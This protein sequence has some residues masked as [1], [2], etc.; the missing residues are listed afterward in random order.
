MQIEV[1][2]ADTGGRKYAIMLIISQEQP[3]LGKPLYW[4]YAGFK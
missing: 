4:V 2:I 1:N 3:L